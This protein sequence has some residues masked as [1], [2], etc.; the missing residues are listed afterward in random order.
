[1]FIELFDE[2]Y[3]ALLKR[4]PTDVGHLMSDECMLLG[5][6]YTP[7]TGDCRFNI[8]LP[9]STAACLIYQTICFVWPKS[10]TTPLPVAAALSEPLGHRR[11]RFLVGFLFETG[12][13]LF[14]H[15]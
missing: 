11:R 10:L 1:M 7:L 15:G 12:Y 6:V 3:K 14:L 4:K 5:P 13:R 2:E 8:S 9:A